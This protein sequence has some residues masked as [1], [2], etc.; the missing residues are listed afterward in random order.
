MDK[1]QL[2]DALSALPEAE[3][4]SVIA[5]ARKNDRRQKM[6]AGAAAMRQYL[7]HKPPTADT[8]E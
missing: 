8:E 7:G 3:A 5:E 6:E 4:K 1:Q 2:I